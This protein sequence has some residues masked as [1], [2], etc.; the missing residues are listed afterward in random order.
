MRLLYIFKNS[1]FMHLL[2][3]VSRHLYSCNFSI[4]AISICENHKAEYGYVTMY[5]FSII[6]FNI[7]FTIMIM[8]IIIIINPTS[9]PLC[10]AFF[11]LSSYIHTITYH[12]SFIL[13][14]LFCILY[15]SNAFKQFDTLFWFVLTAISDSPL[16]LDLRNC[17]VPGK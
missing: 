7:I 9:N 15:S 2:F 8:I 14:P 10:L 1:K 17:R 13:F 3:I 12:L 6:K 11:L 16:S 4:S 5:K